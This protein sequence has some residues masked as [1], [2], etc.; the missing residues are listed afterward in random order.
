MGPEGAKR[1]KHA[2]TVK[3][4]SSFNKY[5]A[6]SLDV[7][8][9]ESFDW[10]I[11]WYEGSLFCPVP[12]NSFGAN[13]THCGEDMAWFREGASVYAVAD[14]LV[15]MIQGQGGDWGFLLCI[16]HRLPTGT[17]VMSVYGHLG[18]DVLVKAGDKVTKGQKVATVGMSCARENG[19][20]GAHLHFG[21]SKGPF[22]RPKGARL[23]MRINLKF[24][25][26]TVQAPILAFVYDPK[27]KDPHGFP[28]LSLIVRFP[29]GKLHALPAKNPGNLGEQL[30]WF[31]GYVKNCVGWYD[32]RKFIEHYAKKKDP[33]GPERSP[34][35]EGDAPE[36][37]D[38][39]GESDE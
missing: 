37:D 23:G 28:G 31:K 16:E 6:A 29:D 2:W 15:R 10:P 9:A 32:P 1:V 19:G 35:G 33:A 14:G 17:Y 11:S 4:K 39:G 36:P 3:G 24:P 22:R 25:D 27:T 12:R 38:E 8:T 18:F 20:Y 5:D 21:V 7:P 30:Y 26:K 34:D 13:G